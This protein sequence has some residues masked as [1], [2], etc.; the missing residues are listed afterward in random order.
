M[1]WLITWNCM[2]RHGNFHPF[3]DV[4]EGAFWEEGVLK[5]LQAS[6]SDSQQTYTDWCVLA[7][8]PMT[9]EN[10]MSDRLKE[11]ING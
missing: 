4:Y 7:I 10:R 1:R 8:V 6:K 5:T 9:V 11:E 2:D 3:M